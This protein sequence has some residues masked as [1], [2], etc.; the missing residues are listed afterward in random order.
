MGFK[1]NEVRYAFTREWSIHSLE[2]C[3]GFTPSVRKIKKIL[4]TQFFEQRFFT[5]IVLY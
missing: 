5:I 1:L 4:V 3:L 2:Q